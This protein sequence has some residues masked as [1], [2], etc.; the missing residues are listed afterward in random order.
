MQGIFVE[1]DADTWIRFDIVA[2]DG[3]WKAFAATR[4]GGTPVTRIN[5]SLTTGG[6][7]N[8]LWLQLDRAGN[9]WTCRYSDDPGLCRNCG[10][11]SYAE[12]DQTLKLK[13]SAILGAL[14]YF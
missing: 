11:L 6:S 1:D 9:S 12:V 5:T 13:P 8:P 14:K 4:D 7:P 10:Y 3:G 2:R